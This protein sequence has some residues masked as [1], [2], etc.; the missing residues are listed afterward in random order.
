MDSFNKAWGVWSSSNG[1]QINGVA[2]IYAPPAF[3]TG[4]GA[5]ELNCRLAF[6]AVPSGAQNTTFRFG[7]TDNLT[8]YAN[9]ISLILGWSGTAAA[10]A[11][12]TIKGGA[13]TTSAWQTN[14]TILAYVATALSFYKLKI[15]ISAAWDSVTFFVNGVQIGSAIATTIPTNVMSYP[16]IAGDKAAGTTANG[17]I[18]DNVSINYQYATP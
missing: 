6:A 8:T 3:L 15:V 12:Q 9:S 1:T 14:P 10:W 13:N 4:L 11:A 17:W 5:L 7:I 2:T 18:V 16:F